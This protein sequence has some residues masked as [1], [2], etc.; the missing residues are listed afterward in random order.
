MEA[1]GKVL[2]RF[3]KQVV[4]L[5]ISLS[6]A[7][8]QKESFVEYFYYSI[9]DHTEFLRIAKSYANSHDNMHTGRHCGWHFAN[10]VTNGAQWYPI[11][12]GMQD[13]NYLYGG[14]MEI[15]VEVS[16]CKFPDKAKLFDEWFNNDEA[17]LTYLEQAQIGIKG[18]SLAEQLNE[19]KIKG[20]EVGSSIVLH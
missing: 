12:G 9:T 13:F 7:Q 10:G 20:F 16:C 2:V 14:T 4:A 3:A 5:N 11:S 18:Y 6:A 15:T 17:F 8:Y 19:N 1:N